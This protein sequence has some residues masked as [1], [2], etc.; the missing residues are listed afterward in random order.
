LQQHRPAGERDVICHG[1]LHPFNVLVDEAGT[2]TVLDWSASMIAPADYDLGFSSLM[3]AE[4]PLVA[5][6]P[7]R[8]VVRAAG[9]ALSRRFIHAYEKASGRTVDAES[10]RWNQ[11]LICLRALVEVAGWAVEG[12]LDDRGGHP[13][14]IGGDA[15][16]ERLGG[17]A[18]TTVRLS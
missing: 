6:G 4:P 12:T 7:L 9:R 14:V 15:F 3:L 17:L 18:G 5:P 13:W 11:G 10:L 8:P 2:A 16:A 1:D